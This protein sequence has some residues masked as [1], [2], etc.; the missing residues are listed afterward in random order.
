MKVTMPVWLYGLLLVDLADLVL[1]IGGR[2][3]GWAL[4]GWLAA[5]LP[6]VP[7]LSLLAWLYW[8]NRPGGA[9]D[10]HEAMQEGK[11]L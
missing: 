3:G 9:V 10:R 4:P 11:K 6:Y 8:A 1:L 7:M 2:F 5:V